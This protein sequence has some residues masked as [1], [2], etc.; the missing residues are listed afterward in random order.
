MLQQGTLN[1]FVLRIGDRLESVRCVIII[2]YL[3]TAVFRQGTVYKG[4]TKG[5]TMSMIRYGSC[6]CYEWGL[7]RKCKMCNCYHIICA[8]TSC[9]STADTTKVFYNRGV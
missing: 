6:S 1:C 5:D 3:R 2:T 9:V 4:V 7:F 8:D